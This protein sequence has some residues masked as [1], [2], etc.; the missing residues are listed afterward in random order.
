[1]LASIY[2]A[3]DLGFVGSC[4]IIL[5]MNFVYLSLV[6]FTCVLP[7]LFLLLTLA[8]LPTGLKVLKHGY[9]PPL[10]SFHFKDTIAEKGLGSR[11]RG[12]A[13][14]AAPMI[15]L[16]LCYLGYDAYIAVLDG[17]TTSELLLVLERECGR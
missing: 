1:M 10:D 4:S 9:F 7:T 6:V 15:G 11:L 2:V 8:F 13:M 12:I 17:R 5:G 16:F 3:K 14:I